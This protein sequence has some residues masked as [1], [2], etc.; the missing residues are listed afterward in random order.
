MGTVREI[1]FETYVAACLLASLLMPEISFAG[2]PPVAVDLVALDKLASA[3]PWVLREY[4]WVAG[5]P[6]A[7]TV[8]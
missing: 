2:R 8:L 6:P 4:P 7:H 1:R 5:L 3:A